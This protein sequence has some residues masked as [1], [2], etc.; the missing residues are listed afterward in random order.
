MV[1]IPCNDVVATNDALV[2]THTK[3]SSKMSGESFKL[4]QFK[5]DIDS[6]EGD[7]NY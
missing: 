2:G 1:Y 5:L 6:E 4:R 7:V 3:L